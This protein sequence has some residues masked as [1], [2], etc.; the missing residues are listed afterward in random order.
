MR[1]VYNKRFQGPISQGSSILVKNV[2]NAKY[3][4]IG[5]QIPNKY[6]INELINWYSPGVEV[7]GENNKLT[8]IKPLTKDEKTGTFSEYDST[9]DLNDYVDVTITLDSKNGSSSQDYRVSELG[10]LEFE[11]L[12]TNSITIT[13]QRNLPVETIIDITQSTDEE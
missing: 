1:L 10:I 3:T 13:A 12:D 7:V 9:K 2:S 8:Y 6:P 4:H 11:N 5:I